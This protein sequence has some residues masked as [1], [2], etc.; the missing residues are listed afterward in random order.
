MNPAPRRWI[1]PALMVASAWGIGGCGAKYLAPPFTARDPVIV[2]A[3]RRGISIQTEGWSLPDK[4]A[5]SHC[6]KYG[7]TSHY[8]GA[9]RYNG[10]YDDRRLH[11]YN[12]V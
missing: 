10:E 8:D 1:V 2:A 6:E 4:Q 5:T 3:D 12:C 7:K 11:F 9:I